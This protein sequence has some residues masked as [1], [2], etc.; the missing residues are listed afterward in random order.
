MLVWKPLKGVIIKLMRM[1]KVFHSGDD[2][3]YM[4]QEKKEHFYLK[5][6]SQVKQF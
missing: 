3:D 4:C 1:L 6:F 5:P 2:I